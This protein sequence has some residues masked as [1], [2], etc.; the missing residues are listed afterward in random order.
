MSFMLILFEGINPTGLTCS[1]SEV[2]RAQGETLLVMKRIVVVQFFFYMLFFI[3][4]DG[5]T[6]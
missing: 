3:L 1:E 5:V 6:A 4:N 2:F